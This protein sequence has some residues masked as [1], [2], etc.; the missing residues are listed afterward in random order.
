MKLVPANRT[1]IPTITS[2]AKSIWQDHYIHII[3]QDQIDYMLEKM[4]SDESLTEQMEK[5]NHQFFLVEDEGNF[6]G[7]VSIKKTEDEVFLNKFYLLTDKQ[8]KGI[9]SRV[10]DLL[11][12]E[13]APFEV[14]RLTVNRQNYKAIN[15]YFKNKFVIEKVEDFQI[16][17]GYVMN[18]FV[19]I[20]RH[21]NSKN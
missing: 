11:K 19:M 15:F 1:H 17:N 5:K 20:Y 21:Q 16:G 3:T 13:A 4:Y 2:L 18:D 10:F 12:Q 8:K 9:G 7:F 6:I 14:I